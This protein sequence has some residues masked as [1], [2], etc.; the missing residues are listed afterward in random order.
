MIIKPTTQWSAAIALPSG[1]SILRVNSG[2]IRLVYNSDPETDD[3]GRSGGDVALQQ[4][5]ASTGEIS[6]GDQIGA[7]A[8]RLGVEAQPVV[9]AMIERIEAMLTA[10]STIEEFRAMIEAGFGQAETQRLANR[11]AAA[12]LAA[13]FAGR[14]DALDG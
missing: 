4:E 1:P 8:E 7:L 5:G 14:E 10:A 3:A 2:S 6:G 11:L 13:E 12:M 9:V